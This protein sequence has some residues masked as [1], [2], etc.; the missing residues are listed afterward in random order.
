M[1]PL[2]SVYLLTILCSAMVL[3][4][5][6]SVPSN[7]RTRIAPPS[8]SPQLPITHAR[9]GAHQKT[10]EQTSGLNFAPVVAYGSGGYE[11]ISVAVADVNGDG[12]PDVVVVNECADNSCEGSSV[13]VLLGNSDGTFQSAVTYGT[14]SSESSWVTVADVN[15]DGKPDLAVVNQSGTVAVLL[16]NG[17]GTFQTAVTYGTGGWEP[18][19]MTVADVNGDGKPDLLVANQCFSN[20]CATNTGAVSVLLGNGDG[21]FQSAVTYGSG[22]IRSFS[23]AV[24]DVNRD[25]KPDL[26]VT[27]VCAS[28]NNCNNG[29]VG[30]LLGNGDGTFQ[31]AVAY[32]SGGYWTLRV[33]VAD[34]NGDGK[35]DVLVANQCADS[36]CAKDGTVGVLLGNGDGTFQTAVAYDSGGSY[37]WSVAVADAN[38]D[39]RPD[40]LVANYEGDTV[41]VL[42]GNG[43][44]TF[45]T[46]VTYGTGGVL[47]YSVAVADV[48]GDG[49][50]DVLVA[51][52]CADKTCA[53]YGSVGVLLNQT[54]GVSTTFAPVVTYGSSGYA[55]NSV[56]VGDV[57]GDGKPD[58]VVANECTSSSNCDNA[59]V[60]VLLGNGNGTFQTV[61]TYDTGGY[62]SLGV[63]LAG[64]KRGRQAGPDCGERLYQ[65]QRLQQRYHI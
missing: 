12:K 44:G 11:A 51:N 54:A 10:P 7:R 37:A 53:T 45:Q 22:G 29:T 64:C 30:V 6:V 16:G 38:G 32:D 56:A 18:F 50:P 33:A 3:A 48:N 35:P 42:L 24:A 57:N 43:D 62:D 20:E 4:Q 28:S 5:S 41:G 46:A 21:T 25:G 23:V 9:A 60:G 61:V 17:D 1:R 58:L 31:T 27:N 55:A 34:V 14:G 26:L 59:T 19:S 47:P 49:R 52:T 13:G 36:T 15:G 39:G 65:Q 8:G 2:R 40:V 63:A